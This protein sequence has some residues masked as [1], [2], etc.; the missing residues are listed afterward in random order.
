M[1]T[2]D[3]ATEA[4]LDAAL[5][6]P[7]W[8]AKIEFESG[9][10]Y[11]WTGMSDLNWD[12]HIWTP[13]GGNGLVAGVPE[14]DEIRA[15]GVRLELSGI[16]SAN[17]ALAIG[18]VRQGKTATVYLAFLDDAGAI[19]G[20]PIESFT[21]R[22]DAPQ[23]DDSGDTASISIA[24]ESDMIL[25]RRRRTRRYTNRDQ[26]MD[27]SADN[28]FEHVVAVAAGRDVFGYSLNTDGWKPGFDIGAPPYF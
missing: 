8:L 11:V 24:V 4:A 20:V 7:A 5:T 2:L 19:I 25:L 16:P 6:R 9:F 10:L 21:G 17:L 12:G 14:T 13:V 15:E 22:V 28:G 26:K 23:I 27:F 3:P 18:S 1:R